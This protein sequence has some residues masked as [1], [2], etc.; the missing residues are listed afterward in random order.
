MTTPSITEQIEAV[1]YAAKLCDDECRGYP[2]A[3]RAAAATLRDL[4]SGKWV[5]VPDNAKMETDL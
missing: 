3:L 1:E 4:Q 2:G 5:R